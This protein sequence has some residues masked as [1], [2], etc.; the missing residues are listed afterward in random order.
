MSGT[1]IK[2]GDLLDS[3]IGESLKAALYQKSL[4]E[5]EKQQASPDNSSFAGD[6]KADNSSEE[7]KEEPKSSKTMDDDTSALKSGDVSSEAVIEKLNLIRSGRSFK[8]A[9][10]S[11]AMTEYVDSFTKAEKTALL[12]FLKGISQIVTGVVQGDDA[13]EPEDADVSMEKGASV[14]KKSIKPNIIKT[15][16]PAQKNNKPSVE[17]TTPPAP[18]TPK[19]K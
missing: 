3:I 12:A 4:Q 1:S 14:Q 8:D 15:S 13:T 2:L 5:K 18:I 16:S 7:P 11:A 10:V 9:D 6:G 19:K 17:D